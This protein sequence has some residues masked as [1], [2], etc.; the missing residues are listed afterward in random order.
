MDAVKIRDDA[1]LRTQLQAAGHM[2][3]RALQSIEYHRFSC[4]EHFAKS[5][6]HKR[7]DP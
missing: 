3:I 7:E 5:R 4:T 1:I 2:D 6:L